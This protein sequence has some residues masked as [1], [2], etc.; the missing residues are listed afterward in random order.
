M[1][2]KIIIIGHIVDDIDNTNSLGGVVSYAGITTAS[3]GLETHVFTKCDPNNDYIGVLESK[4]VL[5]HNLPS[6]KNNITTFQNIYDSKGK[7]VQAVHAIQEKIGLNDFLNQDFSFFKNS[8]ILF[9]S[10]IGEID[11][12][13]ISKL[14]RH[15]KIS[16]VPQGYLRSIGESGEVRH[17]KWTDF[18]KYLKNCQIVFLSGEDL[19]DGGVFQED[20]FSQIQKSCSLF[21]LTKGDKGSVIFE[22]KK[23]PLITTA[24]KLEKNEI[25]DLTGAGD[26]YAGAFLFYFNILNDAKIASI[27]ASLISAVKISSLRGVGCDS[28][29]GKLE[30]ALFIEKREDRFHRFLKQNK[31]CIDFREILFKS[32]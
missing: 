18:K 27:A 7:R 21:A 24:F 2:N 9:G 28:V 13:L 6:K 26:V 25:K 17:K 3:L 14:S 1:F 29:P 22:Y 19:T 15:G 11:F 16:M 31:V 5:V 23:D 30:I 32:I 4:G 8:I 12:S 10:V 20:H